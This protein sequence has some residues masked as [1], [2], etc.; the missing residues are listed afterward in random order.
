MTLCKSDGH[1]HWLLDQ[2]ILDEFNA[3]QYECAKGF[4]YMQQVVNA[5]MLINLRKHMDAYSQ[6][7]ALSR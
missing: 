6:E 1:S 7:Q 3:R 5:H 2:E 4:V